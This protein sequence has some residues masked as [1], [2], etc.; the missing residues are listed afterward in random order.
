ML[1]FG[2]SNGPSPGKTGTRPCCAIGAGRAVPYT[3]VCNV[4]GKSNKKL[5]DSFAIHMQRV[6]PSPTPTSS[7][8]LASSP[9]AARPAAAGPC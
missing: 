7:A 8:T 4:P 6:G 1:N 5:A 2:A 9:A 3:F